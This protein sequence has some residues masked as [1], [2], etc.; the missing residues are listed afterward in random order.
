MQEFF[1]TTY[2]HAEH[3]FYFPYVD[4]VNQTFALYAVNTQTKTYKIYPLTNVI[5]AITVD[6]SS[7]FLY[8]ATLETFVNRS[9]YAAKLTSLDPITGAT[10]D[11]VTIT[12]GGTQ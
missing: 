2:F 6:Q 11:L 12:Y 10:R 7:G 5:S 1:P 9:E 3:I 4:L 8:Y